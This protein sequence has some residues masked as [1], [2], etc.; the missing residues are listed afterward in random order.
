M[1]SNSFHTD[2]KIIRL[3]TKLADT[4]THT[5]RE[6]RHMDVQ[7]K[8]ARATGQSKSPSLTTIEYDL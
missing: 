3:R 4:H 2:H 8:T 1:I 7:G 5:Q 6:Q